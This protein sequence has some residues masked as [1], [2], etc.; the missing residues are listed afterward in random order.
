MHRRY[1]VKP[2]L[3]FGS[4]KLNIIL[5]YMQELQGLEEFSTE[6]TQVHNPLRK[7]VRFH[8]WKVQKKDG[9][10]RAASLTELRSHCTCMHGHI[11]VL[12]AMWPTCQFETAANI[13][14][15]SL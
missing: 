13:H 15:Y 9:G 11:C 5:G 2:V 7:G 8:R 6:V 3:N 12:I 10:I 1:N 4:E 14:Y